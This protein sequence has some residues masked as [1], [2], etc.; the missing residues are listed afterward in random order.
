[1]LNCRLGHMAAPMSS[2]AS[3]GALVSMRHFC[4]QRA[5]YY[6]C[7]AS[8]FVAVDGCA[9]D[10]A[11]CAWYYEASH[12]VERLRALQRLGRE[13]QP[14]SVFVSS[15]VSLLVTLIAPWS[16]AQGGS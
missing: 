15:P 9:R 12:F 16:E 11:G 6:L 3:T 7:R 13:R 4:G 5:P 1:M 8:A 2:S 14:L 10:L